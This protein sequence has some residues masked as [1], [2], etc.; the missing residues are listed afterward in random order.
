MD[1]V[2]DV[3]WL[4]WKRFVSVVNVNGISEVEIV[5][6]FDSIFAFDFPTEQTTP[7]AWLPESHLDDSKWLHSLKFDSRPEQMTTLLEKFPLICPKVEPT[8]DFSA[9]RNP[10]CL[11]TTFA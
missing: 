8:V 4:D 6:G 3:T 5:D 9:P 11:Q 10:S 7:A 2:V 1:D